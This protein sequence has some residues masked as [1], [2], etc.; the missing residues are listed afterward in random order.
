M[1][2]PKRRLKD[3]S[4]QYISLVGKGA[5]KKQILW[6][7]VDA[8]GRQPLG[9]TVK[10]GKVDDEKR[11]VY[12]IVY[13]PDEVDSQGDMMDAGEVEKM[14]YDF[15]RAGRTQQ[16][17]RQ[18]D[19]QPDE[20][21]VAESWL[22]KAADPVFADQPA[23]SWAVAIKVE[24]DDTWALVKSGDIGGISLGGYGK[25]EPIGKDSPLSPSSTAATNGGPAKG[26]DSDA[27]APLGLRRWLAGF[28][29]FAK[30]DVSKDFQAEYI[31]TSLERAVWALRDAL[32]VSIRDKALADPVPA[33]KQSV[34]Q[35]VQFLDNLPGVGV[36]K[37]AEKDQGQAEQPDAP[38]VVEQKKADPVAE[39]AGKLAGIAEALAKLEARLE[40]VEK[41][42][43]GRQSAVGDAAK[44]EDEKSYK[45]L[46]VF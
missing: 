28:L 39:I 9:R 11:L 13:S 29:G 7:A 23:G 19:E 38:E 10:I 40:K 32:H 24:N 16:V 35:F 31:K 1:D 46:R 3:V 36:M 8:A 33:M 6:K 43:P 42:S 5:N 45:G 25:T 15:M 14:A 44:A 12:G 41:A 22:L 37:N 17:D 27:D 21:F 34:A 30:T 26:Q 4:V 2:Q 18:H 20:G